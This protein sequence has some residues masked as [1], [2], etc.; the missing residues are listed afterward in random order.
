MLDLQSLLGY[1]ADIVAKTFKVELVQIYL[2]DD[3]TRTFSTPGIQPQLNTQLGRTTPGVRYDSA[4][5]SYLSTHK[6]TLLRDD[7]ADTMTLRYRTPPS[8]WQESAVRL[9]FLYFRTTCWRLHRDR[10]EAVWGSL[11]LA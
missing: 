7:A 3:A 11:L 8:N 2:R 9:Y 10:R 6:Y 5:A 1:L 4:L